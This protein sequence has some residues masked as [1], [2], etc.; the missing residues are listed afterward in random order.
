MARELNRILRGGLHADEPMSKHTTIGVGGNARLLAEPTSIN[1]VTRVVRYTLESGLAYTVVGKGSNL[2][3]RDG[4][5]DGLIIKLGTHLGKIR[6]NRRTVRA[7][8]GASFARLA[9][10]MTQMGRTGLEFGIGIPGT[11]GGAVR[12]NAGAFGGEISD[13][14]R[15]VQFVDDHGELQ[16]LKGSE[17]T[18]S[19]RKSSL[20][21]GA[22]VLSATFDCPP[23]QINQEAYDR[24]L[25]RK[26]TQPISE[27][28]FGST[29]VNPP[30]RF[31]A[32]MIEGCGLKGRR[33]GGAMI[34][35]KHTNFII[36]VDGS[37]RAED[38]EG[39]IR[40]MRQEVKK[41]YE[42]DPWSVMSDS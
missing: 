17:M 34:S 14:L 3:V 41:K 12:M 39:L 16:V 8:G 30:G 29:F 37:A 26:E 31:A 42:Q 35:D 19:Y 18:F 25:A 7:G 6:L 36:N 22:I 40:L 20:P 15:R 5:Y 10:R 9:R 11:V 2:I 1:Q 27:R 33:R 24:S 4:G 13:V 23:G 21:R 38:V 28:T 32:Q